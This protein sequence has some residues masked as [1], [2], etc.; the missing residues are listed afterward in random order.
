MPGTLT[1]LRYYRLL[2]SGGITGSELNTELADA[3]NL[4]A[5]SIMLEMNYYRARLLSYGTV[6]YSILVASEIAKYT[7]V[8]TD[9]YFLGKNS[10]YT[11]ESINIATE[12]KTTKAAHG[13]STVHAATVDVTANLVWYAYNWSNAVRKY[14]WSSNTD[15]A[16]G[17]NLSNG[18]GYCGAFEVND[19][20]GAFVAG[21]L[22]G[23]SYVTAMSKLSYFTQTSSSV[24]N[25]VSGNRTYF[26]CIQSS[27]AA[28]TTGGA[29]DNDENNVVTNIEKITKDTN[30]ASIAGDA[31]D[32]ALSRMGTASNSTTG[33]IFG[34][35]NSGASDVNI[36]QKFVFSTE[37]TSTPAETLDTART[38]VS[39]ATA[40]GYM[41]LAG[42]EE[43]STQ[44]TSVDKF[45]TDAET[46][47]TITTEIS[48][49]AASI[50]C[51]GVTAGGLA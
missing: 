9:M 29:S 16:H 18:H 28:Y 4:G 6:A 48:S 27:D 43:G 10:S 25:M 21:F 40:N 1:G 30:T 47:A 39:A 49:N 26:E 20:Y 51:N 46:I 3:S 31:L 24:S 5:L 33:Y 37:T 2:L 38:N 35:N 45:D 44:I 50:P 22:G 13:S 12:T 15:A 42:W 11:I 17:S 19:S 34:G 14:D 8:F 41:Y 36:I 32:T 7:F 23:P